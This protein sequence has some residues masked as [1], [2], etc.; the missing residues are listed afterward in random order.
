MKKISNERY[1]E[2]YY[3]E[4]LENGLHVV[5]WQKPK[6]QKSLFMMSTPLGAMDIKQVDEQGKIYEYPLGIAHFLEHKMFAMQDH[7]VMEEF[8]QMGANVN[9]F[10]SYH[11]TAYYTSTTGDPLPPLQL[12]MDFVQELDINEAT[13]EKE[14]GIIIQ[15][16]HMYKEM[17]DQRLLMETY[18][19]LFHQHPM[20]YDIGGD[21]ES[22]SATTVEK[23]EECYRLNYHPSRM[24]LIGVSGQE[25]EV[26]MKVIRENQANKHFSEIQPIHRR[27]VEEP[28]SVYRPC[29]TFHMDV[30]MPKYCVAYKLNGILDAKKRTQVEWA[31]RILLDANFTTLYPEYQEWLNKGIIND[32]CGSDAD[33]GEDYGTIMFYGETT[34][35]DA[36]LQLCEECMKRIS[37]VEIKQEVLEQLQRR[38]YAQ[39]IRSL[40]SFDDIAISYVR[41]KFDQMDPFASL[42]ILNQISMENLADAAGY[43]CDTHKTVTELLPKEKTQ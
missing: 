25:P 26:L 20:R 24:I 38:Y 6:Y 37:R 16:L 2:T 22:V 21:D 36:F 18:A 32:Y 11:E 10:T 5:L 31:L 1:Q 23:L 34:Q 30:S 8:S 4:T 7:D 12:L 43:V 3:E 9:A 35:K 14:K 40:N 41:A 29:Y 17:S 15:E 28:V 42:T 27:K 39:N 13:V 33:F 19:S